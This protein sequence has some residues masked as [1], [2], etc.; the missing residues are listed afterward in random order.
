MAKYPRTRP[1][2]R[3]TPSVRLLS[4]VSTSDEENPENQHPPTWGTAQVRLTCATADNPLLV[5]HQFIASRLATALGIPTTAGE[6]VALP[7]EG[8][9]AWATLHVGGVDTHSAPVDSAELAA[10]H[11]GFAA[12]ISVFDIWIGCAARPEASI[13]ASIEHG[14][15]MLGTGTCFSAT[16]SMF[17]P[18]LDPRSHEIRTWCTRVRFLPSDTITAIIDAAHTRHLIN[19]STC[20]TYKKFLLERRERISELVETHLFTHNVTLTSQIALEFVDA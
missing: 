7:H 13:T 19:T 11:P 14:A 4:A 15:W 9:N 10:M 2:H 5:A 3:H 1:T 18:S 8:G 16:T 6:V 20:N 12:G 17:I